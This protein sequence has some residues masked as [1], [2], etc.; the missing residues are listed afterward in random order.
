MTTTLAVAAGMVTLV[1][2][3]ACDGR[4]VEARARLG[5]R[6]P[7]AAAQAGVAAIQRFDCGVCHDIPGVAGAHGLTAPPL[8]RFARRSFVGGVLPNTPENLTRWLTNPRA[9]DP[10]TAM[11]TVGMSEQDARDIAAYLYELR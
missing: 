4:G 3:C 8:T 6:A 2:S 7:G 10:L 1:L 9:V 5:A 11:P